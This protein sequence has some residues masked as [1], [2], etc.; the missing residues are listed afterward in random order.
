MNILLDFSYRLPCRL[1]FSGSAKYPKSIWMTV[2]LEPPTLA[3][4]QVDG[5]QAS[6]YRWTILLST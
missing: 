6:D 2:A 3:L 1:T 4:A 5:R